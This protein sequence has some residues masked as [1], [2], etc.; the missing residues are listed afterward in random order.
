MSEEKPTTRIIINEGSVIKGGTN[1]TSQVTSRPPPPTPT[2][3]NK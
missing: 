2:K 3:P 1:T